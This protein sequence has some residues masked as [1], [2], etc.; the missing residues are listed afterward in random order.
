[1]NQTPPGPPAK[2]PGAA[3]SAPQ[4]STSIWH[5]I[6][7]DLHKRPKTYLNAVVVIAMVVLIIV[8]S[9]KFFRGRQVDKAA[10]LSTTWFDLWG[11]D[12]GPKARAASLEELGS[13][14][15][16]D[17][18]RALQLYELAVTQKEIAQAAE[19]QA[20]KVAAYER[21]IAHCAELKS[22]YPN[23]FW[24]T[25]PLRP[26]TGQGGPTSPPATL[27]E[28][29]AKSQLEWLKAH[30]FQATAEP[31]PNLSVT[32]ELEDGRKFV[33]GKLFSSVAPYHVQNFVELARSGY[34]DGTGFSR[35][36]QGFK[37]GV[38]PKQGEKP[39]NIA[40]E[41]GHPFTKLTPEDRDD[42]DASADV[43]YSVPD[44]SSTNTLTP[45]RGSLTAIIE[46]AT[47]GDSA[48]RFKIYADEP[49]GSQDT[50][51]AEV[52]EGM[53]VIDSIIGAPHP[54][55]KTM[56]T[57]DLVRVKKVTVQGSVAKPPERPFPPQP[58]MPE[59]KKPASRP[60]SRADSR[61]ESQGVETRETRPTTQESESRPK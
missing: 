31:D 28:E 32:F 26:P 38:T 47:G 12:T 53:D 35:V 61:P 36:S 25:F 41:G 55:G 58:V 52:T 15:T 46:H 4:H 57:K 11:S 3:P 51:F 7:D 30:P 60:E 50:V 44:E 27:L 37:R 48:S 34:F 56:W 10:K 29:Y 14:L 24:A 6:N 49:P 16:D 5:R 21:V 22:K 19:T 2:S 39:P 23:N 54:E 1:M 59:P 20:E 43:G 42:D 33:V 17:Q 9:F 8:L 18:Q 45:K 13:Q 40:V